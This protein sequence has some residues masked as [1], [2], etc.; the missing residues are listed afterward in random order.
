MPAI[1]RVTEYKL[2]RFIYRIN[3]IAA[4]ETLHSKEHSWLDVA[5]CCFLVKHYFWEPPETTCPSAEGGQ[6]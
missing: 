4:A 6:T 3:N 5:S 1:C 2:T